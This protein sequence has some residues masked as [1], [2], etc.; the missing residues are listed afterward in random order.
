MC[1]KFFLYI[2]HAGDILSIESFA[3]H[4]NLVRLSLYG[5]FGLKKGRELFLTHPTP[6]PQRK[7]NNALMYTTYLKVA[8]GS[9]AK[10][11]AYKHLSVSRV[12]HGGIYGAAQGGETD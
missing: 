6:L 8:T 7:P 1:C 11:P 3:A 5:F 10:N 12:H 4:E 9:G 2:K